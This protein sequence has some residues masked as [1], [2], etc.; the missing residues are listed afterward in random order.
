[1]ARLP[2]GEYYLGKLYPSGDCDYASWRACAYTG[3]L[4]VC[5][6]FIMFSFSAPHQI[7]LLQTACKK[8]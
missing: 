6:F 5:L 2:Q 7:Y 4:I 3:R 8:S 1:M